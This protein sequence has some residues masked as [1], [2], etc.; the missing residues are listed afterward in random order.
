MERMED[1]TGYMPDSELLNLLD[2]SPIPSGGTLEDFQNEAKKMV[3][4]RPIADMIED[5]Q[6]RAL[7]WV[8]EFYLLGVQ[9][10]A[11]AYRRLICIEAG[12]EEPDEIEVEVDSCADLRADDFVMPS[13]AT[14]ELLAVLGL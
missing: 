1:V 7:Y 4:F 13:E 3:P 8:R 10:G 9:R 14:M 5:P 11:E 2:D 12:I 6:R